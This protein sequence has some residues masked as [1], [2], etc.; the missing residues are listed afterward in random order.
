MQS[1]AFALGFG[2]VVFTFVCGASAQGTGGPAYETSPTSVPSAPFEPPP[3]PSA[4]EPKPEKPSPLQAIANLMRI[5]GIVRP[6]VSFSG[7]AVES[8]SNPNASAPTAAANPVLANLAD[9]ARLSF[10][11][12]QTRFGLWINEPGV[13]RGHLEFDFIDFAKSSP[14]V[15]SLVRLRIAAVEW[16][17]AASVTLAAGQDWDLPTPINPFGLNLVGG[18]FQAGNTGF[19]RQ[20]IKALVKATAALSSVSRWVCRRQT[21]RPKTPPSSWRASRRSRCASPHCSAAR[22]KSASVASPRSCA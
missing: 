2:V 5:Y 21:P 14:T 6:V 12:A 13:V 11:V 4:P 10:Q 8:F 16:S 9:E 22:E 1:T 19:M 7:S 17:P 20:Q 18:N 3:P 15:Q